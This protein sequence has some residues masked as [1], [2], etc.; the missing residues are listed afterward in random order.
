MSIRGAKR[1]PDLAEGEDDPAGQHRNRLVACF[2]GWV[3]DSRRRRPGVVEWGALTVWAQGRYDTPPLSPHQTNAVVG[4][5]DLEIHHQIN[6]ARTA[7]EREG[8]VLVGREEGRGL[9]EHGALDGL[10]DDHARV[11]EEVHGHCVCVREC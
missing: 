6:H 2:C 11:D 1:A 4:R 10:D 5:H 3:V 9:H 7:G 8:H